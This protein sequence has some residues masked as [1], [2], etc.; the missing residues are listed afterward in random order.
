[1]AAARG[2]QLDLTMPWARSIPVAEPSLRRVEH[3]VRIEG[4]GDDQVGVSR[5][6]VRAVVRAHVVEGERSDALRRARRETVIRRT[7]V[8]EVVQELFVGQ[9]AR[10]GAGLQDVGQ[11]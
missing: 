7:R 4:P 5:K 8:I 3:G 1:A 6:E 9:A 2:T 10:V 11:A